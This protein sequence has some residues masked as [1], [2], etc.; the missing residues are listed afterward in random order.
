MS[1]YRHLVL[2]EGQ[3]DQTLYSCTGNGVRVERV[4]AVRSFETS[5]TSVTAQTQSQIWHNGIRTSELETAFSAG[6][7]FNVADT[8]VGT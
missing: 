6:Q 7:T 1:V 2:C 8:G 4:V 5:A 3:G